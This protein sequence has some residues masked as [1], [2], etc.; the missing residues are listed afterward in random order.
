MHHHQFK[1]VNV[2]LQIIADPLKERCIINALRRTAG[3]VMVSEDKIFPAVNAPDQPVR[4]VRLD[5]VCDIAQNVQPVSRSHTVID[6]VNN[7]IIHLFDIRKRAVLKMKDGCVSEMKVGC[8]VNHVISSIDMPVMV[9]VD[10]QPHR[11]P[12][13]KADVHRHASFK[14]IP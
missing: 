13:L 9:P 4:L 6:V 1:A 3:N 2:H 5:A 14:S 11:F 12:L 7:G 10:S 8:E